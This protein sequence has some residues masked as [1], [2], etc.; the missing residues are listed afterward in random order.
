ML[1]TREPLIFTYFKILTFLGLIYVQVLIPIY[2]TGD[3]ILS[4]LFI[5]MIC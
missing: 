1:G 5:E 2:K 4:L 3:P